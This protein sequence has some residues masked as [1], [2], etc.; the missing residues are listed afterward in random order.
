MIVRRTRDDGPF[1][2]DCRRVRASRFPIS[3][4]EFREK[5]IGHRSWENGTLDEAR[6]GVPSFAVSLYVVCEK[7]SF[8]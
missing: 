5:A 6:R 7:M 1:S 2:G 3:T 8:G 4:G